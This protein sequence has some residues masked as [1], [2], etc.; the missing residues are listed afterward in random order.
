MKFYFF[1]SRLIMSKQFSKILKKDLYLTNEN[2]SSFF[3]EFISFN[4]FRNI[5]FFFQFEKFFL[6]HKIKSDIFFCFENQPWE[7]ILLYFI[8]KNEYIKKSYGVIH[9]PIRFWDFRFINF[10]S[11]KKKFLGYFNPDKILVNSPFVKKILV[12]N[13]FNKSQ[14][15]EVETLRYANLNKIQKKKN[16]KISKKL[17]ILFL[18][19]YD[20][21]LNEFFIEFINELKFD[22]KY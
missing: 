6:N 18:S 10:I 3:E 19:D 5:L 21:R 13:G 8:K 9:S 11:K 22:T 7:K 14:L 12:G 4:S 15:I 2:Y 1:T 16:Y 17:N 20:D